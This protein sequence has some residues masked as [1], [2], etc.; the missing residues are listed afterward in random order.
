MSD[1]WGSPRV[2]GIS[3]I[4]WFSSHCLGG[5]TSAFGREGIG[6]SRRVGQNAAMRSPRISE[7]SPMQD[8]WRTS[9]S[10]S[11][12]GRPAKIGE[13]SM[14]SPSLVSF[15]SSSVF[16][17]TTRCWCGC[18]FV[19]CFRHQPPAEQGVGGQPPGKS[20]FKSES[21]VGG[22]TTGTFDSFRARAV[23][24]CIHNAADLSPQTCE[25]P[26]RCSGRTSHD[27]DSHP[28]AQWCEWLSP[29]PGS[30]P[31]GLPLR[32][33]HP[34]GRRLL[35]FPCGWYWFELSSLRIEDDVE[36]GL[37]FAGQVA[38]RPELHE[39]QSSGRDGAKDLHRVAI[40]I[41]GLL[42]SRAAEVRGVDQGG[43]IGDVGGL[44][45]VAHARNLSALRTLGKDYFPHCGFIFR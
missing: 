17:S 40:Q 36:M 15:S 9:R 33:V 42:L 24:S 26:A 5:S 2:L 31:S 30:P 27:H 38:D 8:F 35:A 11:S 21:S 1:I 37:G 22:A 41:L 20:Y 43:G 12:S 13:D 29:T 28:G 16:S 19:L 14:N 10:R 23:A 4:S 32:R 45:G 7:Y 25:A 18:I 44:C 39:G 3:G 6:P 34:S